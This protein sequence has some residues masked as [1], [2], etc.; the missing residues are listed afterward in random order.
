[1]SSTCFWHFILVCKLLIS[2]IA[3]LYLFSLQENKFP[4][5]LLK[6]MENSLQLQFSENKIKYNIMP[7]KVFPVPYT[8]CSMLLGASPTFRFVKWAYFSLPLHL[9]FAQGI[10]EYPQVL[11]N[12]SACFCR[13]HSCWHISSSCCLQK[14]KF[15]LRTFFHTLL[16]T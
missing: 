6:E 16:I 7:K 3:I 14:L 8:S 9:P 2:S 1:M 12:P 4:W 11:E 15:A 13:G 5:F 10:Q